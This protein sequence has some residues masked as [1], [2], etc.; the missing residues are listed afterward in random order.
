MRWGGFAAFLLLLV[1]P[2]WGAAP[3]TG[4][5]PEIADLEETLKAGKD[6]PAPGEEAK[7]PLMGRDTFKRVGYI[8]PS[9]DGLG[10]VIGN[11]NRRMILGTGEIVYIDIG[12]GQGA[13][14]GDRFSIV[15]ADRAIYP[16]TMHSEF[17]PALGRWNRPGYMEWMPDFLVKEK[18]LG[19]LVR[20][21]GVLEIVKAQSDF[22]EAVILEAFLPI[23][24]GNRLIAY[25]EPKVPE[26]AKDYKPKD[27]QG[28][29]VAF[30]ETSSTIGGQ[31][32]VVYID[33]GQAHDVSPGDRF[34]IYIIPEV[35]TEAQWY[36][37]WHRIWPK[38]KPM[39]PLVI[40]ELQVVAVQENTATAVVLESSREL[41]LGQNIRYVPR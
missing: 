20:F 13:A 31:W 19:Y 24:N 11:P 29:V 6:K 38:T 40:G 30:K 17:S 10:S 2:V 27:I 4:G 22:S 15:S 23:K 35:E 1:T 28:R 7:N 14:K 18:K 34:E 32:D 5:Q 9:L 33:K 12:A 26:L 25:Q 16:S 41:M 8:I 36:D 37:V 3:S 39:A 21:L